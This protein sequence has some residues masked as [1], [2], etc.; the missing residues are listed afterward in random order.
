VT[1]QNILR[2]IE[3]A[4]LLHDMGKL[5]VPE[6]IL[7]KPGQLTSAEYERMKLHAPLGADMLSAVDFPYPVVPIVRHH[8]ENWDGSGYP[9]GLAGERIPIGARVLSVVD[10]Y[11]ALRSHRPYRRALSPAQALAIIRER[12]GTMYDPAVVDAFERIQPSIETESMDEPLP[13]VLDQFARAAR[14]LH[15]PVEQDGQI[16]PIELRLAATSVLLQFFDHMASLGPTATLEDTCEVAARHLR[17]L[18]PAALVVFYR[19]DEPTDH[20]IASY[21]SGFGEALVKD[22]RIAMGHGVS[23]WVCAYRQSVI[24]ADSALDFGDRLAHLTPRVQSVLGVPLIRQQSVVGVVTLYSAQP[25]A[26]TDDQRQAIELISSAIAEALSAAWARQRLATPADN[27]V[28]AEPDLASLLD[29]SAAWLA[30]NSRQLGVLCVK[31]DGDHELMAHAAVAVSQATRV[32]DLVF[33]PDDNEL[34]VLMPEC[35][36]GA[37]RLVV[38][39]VAAGL[40]AALLMSGRARLPLKIGFA[41]S[42]FDGEAVETLLAVARRRLTALQ[43]GMPEFVA[44]RGSDGDSAWQARTM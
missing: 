28:A 25:Q 12:R 44:T 31:N 14:E 32:A 19:R 2:A 29:R 36:P 9:D 20:V 27:S 21:A 6:H 41:C 3:A 23:G 40:P 4:A 13:D 34:V 33:R 17:R 10:C 16:V 15:R 42:P 35:D 38:D 8:H 22:V 5:A 37:G 43:P 24:N 1:D 30:V 39:R 26:Y 7:N 11:D 18:A